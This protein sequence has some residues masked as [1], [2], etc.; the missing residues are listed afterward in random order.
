MEEN[1]NSDLEVKKVQAYLR[2]KISDFKW[3]VFFIFTLL[4]IRS[5]LIEPYRIPTGSMQ[6]TLI[7]GDFILVN[8]MAY[9]LKIPFSDLMNKPLYIFQTKGP[10]RG[11]VVV[12]KYP[13]DRSINYI[14]RVIAVPGDELEIKQ[15]KIYL[16]GK[17]LL[18]S[19]F[20]D[21]EMRKKFEQVFKDYNYDF[22]Y[23]EIDGVKFKYQLNRGNFYKQ[24]YQKIKIPEGKYFVVGD[25]R[26]YSFDSREWG[27]VDIEEIKGKALWVWFSLTTPGSETNFSFNIDRMGLRI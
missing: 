25:N 27:F 1:F 23:S 2:E 17:M 8:K 20:E 15:K 22:F 21:L 4:I 7:N 24:N 19:K 26:D 16:N 14:K 5:I 12:F 10:L 18:S 11:E 3:F 13:K 6:P 9:G